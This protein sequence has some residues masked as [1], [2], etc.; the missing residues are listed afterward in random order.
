MRHIRMEVE[1]GVGVITIDRTARF[2][3]LDVRRP[4]PARPVC[5][6]HGILRSGHC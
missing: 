1:A 3:S 4:G 2:N 5:N 6:W